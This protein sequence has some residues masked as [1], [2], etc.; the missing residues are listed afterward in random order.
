MQ[1]QFA[2]DS[3]NNGFL[4]CEAADATALVRG[5]WV[6]WDLVANAAVAGIL[7]ETRAYRISKVA[8]GSVS[9]NCRVAGVVETVPQT[10]GTSSTKG[11][12][13]L[14][15]CFGFH[16]SALCVATTG[17][18]AAG[19][20]LIGS[21]TAGSANEVLAGTTNAGVSQLIGASLV[22]LSTTPSNNAVFV[23]T[24]G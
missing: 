2:G 5:D 6:L 19:V 11:T 12:T 4:H 16:D 10:Y 23:H 20:G 9:T 17:T 14:V 22:A 15:Q 18:P 21:T 1:W 7:R 3:P 8:M 24:L 13:L